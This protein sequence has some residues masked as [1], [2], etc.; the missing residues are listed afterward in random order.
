MTRLHAPPRRS[1]APP[2]ARLAAITAAASGRKVE[3]AKPQ[4]RAVAPAPSPAPSPAKRRSPAAQAAYD[5]AYDQAAAAARKERQETLATVKAH[6]L[7]ANRQALAM[8][9]FAGGLSAEQIIE[10]LQISRATAP[11]T[12]AEVAEDRQAAIAKLWDGAIKK[13]TPQAERILA[14]QRA[15]TNAP[16]RERKP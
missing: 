11:A 12:A 14:A 4:P 3:H 5:R 8:S 16:G 2:S 1:A 9:L 6:P 10:A 13:A 15:M 7:F